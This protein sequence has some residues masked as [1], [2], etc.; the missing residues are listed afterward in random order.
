MTITLRYLADAPNFL[1]DAYLTDTDFETEAF[2]PF[3]LLVRNLD[4]G[5]ETRYFATEIGEDIPIQRI[6]Y[7]D[8]QRVVATL[9]AAPQIFFRPFV[10]GIYDL[11]FGD[12]SPLQSVLS[13][14]ELVL[15]LTQAEGG[16][17]MDFSLWAG[18]DGVIEVR[19]SAF[20]DFLTGTRG[21]DLIQT[22]GGVD[23]VFATEGNDTIDFGANASFDIDS[24]DGALLYYSDDEDRSPGTGVTFDLDLARGTGTITAPEGTDSLFN[25]GAAA[26]GDGTGLLLAGTS[27]QDSFEIDGGNGTRVEILAGAGNDT[28]LLRPD[29]V[30]QTVRVNFKSSGLTDPT[31]GVVANF[32]TGM[33]AQDGYGGRDQITIAGD[34]QD[35]AFEIRGTDL[36]DRLIGRARDD[37]F[38]MLGGDDTIDGGGGQD[39]IVYKNGDASSGVIV[40]LVAGVATGAVEGAAFTDSLRQV[41]DVYGTRFRD[42]IT[43]DDGANLLESGAANDTLRGG[44]GDDTLNGGEGDDFLDGGTGADALEGGTGDDTF[45]FDHVGDRI[46]DTERTGSDRLISTVDVGISETAVVDAIFLRGADD[47]RV[48]GDSFSDTRIVGNAGDNV[49]IES[50]G[51][52]TLEGGAGDDVF[53]FRRD[54]PSEARIVD[55]S[56]GDRLALEDRFFGVGGS[57]V[58]IRAATPDQVDAALQSGRA[59][60]DR[61][62]GGLFFDIDG[63]DG[64]E[65]RSLIV[66]IE[67]APT[68]AASDILLF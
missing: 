64:P 67:G 35:F 4:N 59:I 18:I 16:F 58:D 6:T 52:D 9:D 3:G 45:V 43:G 62:T 63:A 32:R 42:A 13:G 29:T 17:F 47:L 48:T 37:L 46:V 41:E 36:D 34:A 22:G 21:D 40:D 11:L 15:D 31:T 56:E 20:D 30:D 19:G 12:P 66:T 60:Y 8:G 54:A 10:S 27:G 23:V 26:S 61:D 28:I 25:L 2:E 1:T 38:L 39:Q 49:L 7:S 44:G 33:V 14:D 24:S 65:E 53:A 55:F 68:L 50:G 5:F 51:R 57:D